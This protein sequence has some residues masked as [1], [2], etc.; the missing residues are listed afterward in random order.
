[1]ETKQSR[2]AFVDVCFHM[3]KRNMEIINFSCTRQVLKESSLEMILLIFSF[4]S[5]ASSE[6]NRAKVKYMEARIM[7]T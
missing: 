4:H 2:S 3:L 1:M 5:S 7:E 6:F